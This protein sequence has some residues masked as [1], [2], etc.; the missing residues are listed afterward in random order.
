MS[1]ELP[2]LIIPVEARI[3]RLE[4]AL[5][6]ASQAQNNAARTMEKRAKQSAN[7]MAQS[8]ESAGTRMSAAFKTIVM[9]KIAGGVGTIAAMIVAGG[10]AAVRQT[11]KGMAQIGD[12]AKRSGMQ[13]EA[14]Q[15]WKF[16]AEQNR[17]GVDALTDG[18]KELNLRADEFITTGTGSAAESFKRLGFTADELETKLK[19]PSALML[20]IIGRLKGLDRAAQIRISDE[21]FGGTGGEQFVQLIAQGEAGLRQTITRAHELGAVIDSDMIAKATELDKKFGEVETR[22]ASIWRT[23]VVE[24]SYFFNLID[25]DSPKLKFD[26]IDTERLLGKGTSD[27][28]ADLPEVPQGALEQIESLKIEYADLALEA[29][30][31][32]LPLSDAS[33]AMRGL[34]NEAAAQAL[35]ALATRISDAASEFEN[36]TISGEKYAEKL[37]DV[38][39]EAQDTLTAMSELDQA[40]LAGVIG[41]VSSLLEWIN[42][43]PGAAATARNAVNELTAMDFGTPLAAGGDLLPPKPASPLAPQTSDR[44][45]RAP[46]N[47]DFGIPDTPKPAGGGG[48]GGAAR[49][50]EFAKALLSIQAETAALE[51]EA[52]VFAATAAAGREFGDAVEF[53]KTKSDLLNEAI[54]SGKQI[55]PELEA[56]IDRLAQAYVTAGMNAEK[57][58]EKLNRIQEAGE[59]GA[60]TLTDLFLGVATGATSAGEALKGLLLEI[61]KAQLQKGLTGIFSGAGSGGFVSILGGLLGFASGGYTGDGGKHE[62]AGLVHRGEFV[63]SKTATRNLGVANLTRLHQSALKGY[64]DGGL[65]DGT[66]KL[67]R[68]A[69]DSPM[70]RAQ[71]SAPAFVVNAP[72]TVNGSAGTPDQNTD[73]AKR[74]AKEMEGVMRGAM[75]DEMRKQTRPGSML[76]TRMR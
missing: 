38:V 50:D 62:P 2:G 37:K 71:A 32:V 53:E 57:A 75:Q 22:L 4:K 64:S 7:N 39:L 15:E 16:V 63:L 36:G 48:G 5:K 59:K 42:L 23:G 17:I 11:V 68:A 6:K 27:N 26:P 13:V 1:V 60:Q 58:A 54:K 34:G 3:D 61:L 49:G 31:L 67:A 28:L 18:F 69:G 12:A 24:A 30:S 55:T 74:M 9:P 19:D 65:V 14:F 41:Q 46:N 21:L 43:L 76:N 70:N 45:K 47:P 20:E 25:R 33:S 29:S 44:P 40:R 52:V 10:V 8:Y 72:I 66:G 51:R 56:D 73:L 35:T